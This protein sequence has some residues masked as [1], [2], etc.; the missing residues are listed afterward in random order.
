MRDGSAGARW[1]TKTTTLSLALALWAAPA[2]AQTPEAAAPPAAPPAVPMA[3]PPPAVP[4]PAAVAVEVKPPT[5][6]EAMP[7]TR[8]DVLP[9]IDV[10][11]WTRIG[12]TFQGSDPKKL[13]DWHMS[14]A[15]VELHAGGKIHKNVGVTL[16]LNADAAGYGTTTG[17]PTAAIEDA[18]ISFDFDDAFHVWAGHLLVPVD[19]ANA[20]GPFFMI[21]WNYPGIISVGGTT[22]FYL[23]REGAFGRNNG[24]V[25]WGDVA[26]NKVTYL[27]GVFDNG[28]PAT[29]PLY[30]GRLRLALWDTEPGFWGNGSFFGDKNM[31]SLG[32]GGQYQKAATGTNYSEVNVDVLLE[33]KVPGGGWFTAEGAYYH[34]G[35]DATQ[36]SDSAYILAAFATG[37]MG[38]GNVQPMAR[39]QWFKIKGDNQ[40]KPINFDAGISYLIKGPALRVLGTYSYTKLGDGITANAIQLGA[41]AIFF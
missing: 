35:V 30:S 14:A 13:N 39:F 24:V 4:P 10:G 36:L 8:P 19:R 1:T 9:P 22:A 6:A 26:A 40:P 21:P 41:Q 3:A 17:N 16:N 32:V 18:I 15:Y 37:T 31:L 2:L 7:A 29:T 34:Y 38:V 23:P 20:S 25:V 12:S 5:A 28:D 27:A 33:K 11:A